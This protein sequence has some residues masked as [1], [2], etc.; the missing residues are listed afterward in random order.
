MQLDG[1]EVVI[2][3][4]SGDQSVLPSFVDLQTTLDDDKAPDNDAAG[5]RAAC[6]ASS[7]L[8]AA[9]QA[10]HIGLLAHGKQ[11]MG[12]HTASKTRF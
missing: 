1:K 2:E 3:R 6:F 8:I 10:I 5:F 11:Y 12:T 9:Y 4:Y 7:A